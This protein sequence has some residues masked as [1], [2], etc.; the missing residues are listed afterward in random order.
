MLYIQEQ[1]LTGSQEE[2]LQA[3]PSSFCDSWQKKLKSYNLDAG[4]SGK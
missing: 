3:L 1:S 2:N 4:L